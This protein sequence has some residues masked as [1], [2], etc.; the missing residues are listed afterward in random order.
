MTRGQ[1]FSFDRARRNKKALPEARWASVTGDFAGEVWPRFS[2]SFRI[3]AGDTVFTIG[4]CFARNIERYLADAGCRVPMQDLRL[5]PDEWHG[6]ANAAMNKFH[7]PAFRQSLEWTARIFDRDG[8][9][10]WADCEPLAFGVGEDLWFDMDMAPIGPV[11]RTRFLER[12]QQVYEVFAAAFSADGLIACVGKLSGAAVG[13][14]ILNA[15]PPAGARAFVQQQAKEEEP[16]APAPGPEAPAAS[17]LAEEPAEIPAAPSSS[18]P[19]AGA[20][21]PEQPTD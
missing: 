6:E 15:A 13:P 11:S 16:A 21:G 3:R 18:A 20:A 19:A 10:E 9:V 1:V 2:P 8:K 17:G 14:V 7:P 5:P 12:R 4:S